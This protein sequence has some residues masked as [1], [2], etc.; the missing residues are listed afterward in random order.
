ML[1]IGVDTHKRSWVAVVVDESGRPVGQC[2][3]PAGTVEAAELIAWAMAIS[4][5][6]GVSRWGIEVAMHYGR[7]L[8]QCVL[9]AGMPVYEV[10][11]RATACASTPKLPHLMNRQILA[12][13]GVRSCVRR[14]AVGAPEW[15]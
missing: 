9:A 8:A 4:P 3:R 14:G 1:T 10:P 5:S 7:R 12:P 2:A 13:A 11:G 6:A 15:G